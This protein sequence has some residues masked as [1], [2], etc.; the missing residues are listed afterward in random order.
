[1]ANENPSEMS[2]DEFDEQGSPPPAV[3]DFDLLVE[4]A[5]S[6]RRFV[7]GGVGLGAAAFVMGTTAL[8]SAPARAA[9]RLAFAQV[10]ANGRDTIT[11]PPGYRWHTVVQ[12]GE[13]MWSGAPEFD[14]VTHVGVEEE[15]ADL[16][17]AD[18]GRPAVGGG[19]RV[20][21]RV[22]L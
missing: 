11:V 21:Q 7:A 6:R 16:D 14:P 17:C 15:V 3:T 9:S 18:V 5:L 4:Q 20:P 1:M 13:P 2:F 8:T 19:D 12:W 22:S 10:A